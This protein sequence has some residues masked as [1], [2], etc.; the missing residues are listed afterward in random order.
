MYALRSL[1]GCNFKKK[2]NDKAKKIRAK[3]EESLIA[4]RRFKKKLLSSPTYSNK[5]S[6]FGKEEKEERRK[7]ENVR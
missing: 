3:N 7:G 2:R 5:L 1:T 6:V 4:A